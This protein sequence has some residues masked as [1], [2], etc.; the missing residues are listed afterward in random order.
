M[1]IGKYAI[2]GMM[3]NNVEWNVVKSTKMMVAE[4]GMNIQILM[5]VITLSAIS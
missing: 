3:Q 1:Y 2:L 4:S 5:V